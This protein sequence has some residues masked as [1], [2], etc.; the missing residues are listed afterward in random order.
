MPKDLLDH[1]FLDH[2]FVK[3]HPYTTTGHNK[4]AVR[5]GLNREQHG[6]FIKVR[7]NEAIEDFNEG[8]DDS[9][10]VY[11][12]FESAINFNLDLDK[13]D[14]KG[15]LRIAFVKKIIC[16]NEDNKE[17]FKY[18]TAVY[19]DKKA[20]SNFLKKIDQY[21]NE[22]TPKSKDKE[23]PTPKNNP[24]ISNIADIKAAT[25]RSFWQEPEIP[26]P[27]QEEITWWE[28]WLDKRIEN[29]KN[30]H[31]SILAKTG[32]QIGQQWIDFPEHT[33]GL[34]KA[35]AQQLS[36][37]LLYTDSLSELRKPRETAEFFTNLNTVEQNEW[38]NDLRK[39]VENCSNESIISVCLLDSGVNR[40]HPLLQDLI[41]ERNLDTIIPETGI[42]DSHSRSGH[43][44]P[45]AG[46]IMYGDLSEE[47][48]NLT[49]VKIYHHLESIKIIHASHPHEPQNYGYV[50][51]EAL[52][53]AEIINPNHKRIICLAI[54]SEDINHRGTPTVW[55][56]ALDQLSFGSIDD[57][58]ERSLFL[59]SSGN[60]LDEQR[61][62]YPIINDDCSINDP[63]QAFNAVTVGAYTLK[64][65][66]DL[67]LH[68]NAEILADRGAMAPCNTT[69]IS[70]ENTWCRKPDIVME[71][72]N[73]ALQNENL[74]YPDSLSL[75]S[76]SKRPDLKW[77][78]SFGD[79]S[80]ATA[81]ASRL[82]ARLYHHYPNLWPETIRALIIHSADWTSAMLGKDKAHIKELDT[83]QKA[84]LLQTVGYGV[85]NLLK[86]MHSAS[87]SLSL[88]SESTF[89]P[90][91]KVDSEIKTNDFHLYNLPWPVNELSS[92]LNAPV[93]LTI[94]LSYFIEP[95]PGNK[96]YALA[97]NYMS[98]GL[99][100]KMIH[101]REHPSTFAGR[102][103]KAMREEDYV[104]ENENNNWLLGENLRNK[105][106][107][108]KDIWEGSAADLA[109]RNLIAIYPTGGWWKN[110]K[111]LN[112]HNE[113]VRYSLVIT[114]DTQNENIDIYNTVKNQIEIPIAIP[115]DIENLF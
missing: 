51:L 114:I 66:L 93:K 11:L 80:G 13:F 95:N 31:L 111:K 52:S 59:V 85:P 26:F 110:R 18:Q 44:T 27:E 90:L 115:I 25:L 28:V 112:R 79:T 67:E 30:S 74:I 113:Q 62:S 33:V 92:L 2:R 58:N 63:A 101:S 22:F 103:S 19:L 46:L 76:T 16:E 49:N 104:K 94:T 4:L 5:S 71:G 102:I 35:S 88:I 48:P 21:L 37:T 29:T 82:A 108:H 77:L 105:G 100:F 23:N 65:Q 38:V 41:P 91:K 107:I 78:T 73:H 6:S 43:G 87:N 39:R 40:G 14:D 34:I 98:Y 10:F 45:M 1:L 106:S 56:S 75:L 89:F 64:D 70:W 97:N 50:T 83:L 99:R 53:K 96:R 61:S 60:L 86:A 54:S 36:E 3:A 24:L 109:T 9:D 72:G 7:F 32:L 81:L 20:I 8:K 12:V 17:C 57:P 47:L 55:S 84:K 15:T 68:P 42:A 69:S